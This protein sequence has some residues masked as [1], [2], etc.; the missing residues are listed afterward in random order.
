[1]ATDVLRKTAANLGP[2]SLPRIR[3]LIE[4]NS[5]WDTVDSVAAWTVGPLVFNNPQ[6]ASDMDD[7][8]DDENIW[9]ARTAILHQLSFKESTDAARLFAY[10]QIRATDTEFFIRK[11]IGWALRQFARVEPDSVRE[12]V[13]AN[14]QLSG[15]TRREAMKHL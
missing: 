12:F 10:A 13:A 14:P 5:W 8:I 6:L 7:W 1:M 15:L 11:A 4:T 9:V 2:G 3:K